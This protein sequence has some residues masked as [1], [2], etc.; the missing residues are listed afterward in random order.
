MRSALVP[1]RYAIALDR[2]LK[3]AHR[4]TLFVTTTASSLRSPEGPLQMALDEHQPILP[5]EELAI[6]QVGGR[7]EDADSDGLVSAGGE[8]PTLVAQQ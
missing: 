4:A 8:Q 7:T 6:D 5:I 3:T 2:P 1:R